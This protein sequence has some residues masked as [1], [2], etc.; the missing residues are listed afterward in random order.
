[1]ICA[2]LSHSITTL[3]T[4]HLFFTNHQKIQFGIKSRVIKL[5]LLLR[6]GIKTLH[7]NIFTDTYCSIKEE[8]G[9]NIGQGYVK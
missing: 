6:L 2:I 3:F 8:G 9:W 4:T 5:T 7:R 1:M